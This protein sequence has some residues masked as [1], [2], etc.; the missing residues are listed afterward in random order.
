MHRAADVNF[1]CVNK[2]QLVRKLPYGDLIAENM[3]NGERKYSYL[4]DGP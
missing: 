2:I 3:K 1:D 4:I